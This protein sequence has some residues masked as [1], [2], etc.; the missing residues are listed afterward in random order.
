MYTHLPTVDSWASSSRHDVAPE[1]QTINPHVLHPEYP[2]KRPRLSEPSPG[3]IYSTYQLHPLHA[4]HTTDII[5]PL[6]II[7]PALCEPQPQTSALPSP[8]PSRISRPSPPQLQHEPEPAPDFD[9]EQWITRRLDGTPS[10]PHESYIQR[11]SFLREFAGRDNLRAGSVLVQDAVDGALQRRARAEEE[12]REAQRR[13]S[14]AEDDLVLLKSVQAWMEDELSRPV[15]PP[16]FKQEYEEECELQL[17]F[18]YQPITPSSSTDNQPKP[19]KPKRP[20]APRPL[21]DPNRS[22]LR[23]S[24]TGTESFLDYGTPEELCKRYKALFLWGSYRKVTGHARYRIWPP[25]RAEPGGEECDDLVFVTPENV[26]EVPPHLS[27]P[28]CRTPKRFRKIPGSDFDLRALPRC[29]WLSD[30]NRQCCLIC[31]RSSSHKSGGTNLCGADFE[32]IVGH[33]A[34]QGTLTELVEAAQRRIAS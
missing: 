25:R 5:P 10:T 4:Q 8:P 14:E 20:R 16:S 30:S 23:S 32:A 18:D 27:C 6:Q 9:W 34:M 29:L 22:K 13:L 15:T 7:D 11:E 2:H 3:P 24:L 26:Y 28:H 21:A 12:I 33:R 31:H 17:D 1:P 19:T